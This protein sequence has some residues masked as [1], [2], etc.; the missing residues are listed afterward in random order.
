VARQEKAMTTLS[1]AQDA[2][3]YNDQASIK[4]HLARQLRAGRLCAVLG[5]GASAQFKLPQWSGLIDALCNVSNITLPDDVKKSGNESA[6]EWVLTFGFKGDRRKF[7]EAVREALYSG[8]DISFASLRRNDLL[9]ALGALAMASSR[10]SVSR[11]ITFNFDDLL[12]TYLEFHGFLVEAIATLP[13]WASRA[14]VRVFHPHGLLPIGTSR[15]LTNVVFTARDFDEVVGR[16][17]LWRGLTLDVFRSHTCL[18]IGLSGD[19]KNLR[20]LLHEARESHVSRELNHLRWGFRFA[21]DTDARNFEWD[22]RGIHNIIVA[23]YDRDIPA[24][25]FEIAQTAASLAAT[26]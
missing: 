19:D 12:E 25:L 11:V 26:R 10:G 22:N 6:S 16:S 9:A 20:S 17:D 13:T 23:D 21:K 15:A 2:D 7:A 4:D 5:S 18:F 1:T 24:W 3:F 14:D 8:C